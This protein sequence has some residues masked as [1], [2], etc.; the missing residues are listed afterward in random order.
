MTGGRQQKGEAGMSLVEILVAMALMAA[1]VPVFAPLLVSATRN[2]QSLSAQSQA[3]DELRAAVAT[4][5]RELRSAEC[6]PEPAPNGPAGPTLR[7]LTNA[8]LTDAST[9]AYEVTYSV[10]G[11]ELRRQVTGGGTTIAASGLVDAS[12]TF[13]QVVT[14]RRSVKVALRIQAGPE[15]PVRDVTTTIAGRNA[16]RDC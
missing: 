6:I 14:P 10:A 11:D 9:T 4:I 3:L 1:I 8:F 2:A 7:F 16:W 12:N 15:E 13:Q 5:G